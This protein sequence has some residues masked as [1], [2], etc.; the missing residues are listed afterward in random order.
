M[1]GTVASLETSRSEMCDDMS[2]AHA[3]KTR[4][5]AEEEEEYEGRELIG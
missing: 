2:V 3:K 1:V 5:G 4:E